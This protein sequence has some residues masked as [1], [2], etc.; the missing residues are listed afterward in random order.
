MSSASP[1]RPPP[2]RWRPRRR[3]SIRT[4][5][6][7]ATPP[8]PTATTGRT[9]LRGSRRAR[10]SLSE[11]SS[12]QSE[13][14]SAAAW[15]IAASVSSSRAESRSGGSIGRSASESICSTSQ[16]EPLRFSLASVIFHLLLKLLDRAMDQH[17][18]RP[19]GAAQ[20]PRDLAV[21]H[22]E[23]EAHDQRLAAVVGEVLEVR[24]HLPQLL[25]P[26]GDR[27]GVV[28]G[29]GGGVGVAW[30]AAIA[31]ASSNGVCARRERSW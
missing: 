9:Q 13:S 29:W 25:P 28:A 1:R 12:A 10:S 15:V 18:G 14:S 3:I 17:L 19:V 26:L 27:L 16:V 2:A 11:S 4:R 21:V 23:G 30:R 6:P 5:A 24:H 31:C 22:A 8:A 7:V 20:L